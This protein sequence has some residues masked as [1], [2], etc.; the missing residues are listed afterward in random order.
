MFKTMQT[1]IH[2]IGVLWQLLLSS[3]LDVLWTSRQENRTPQ[4]ISPLFI[5][6]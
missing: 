1:P 6:C 2:L 4:L 3:E 5:F